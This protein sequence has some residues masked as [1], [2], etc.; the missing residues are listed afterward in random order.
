MPTPVINQQLDNMKNSIDSIVN[1]IN[2]LPF[3]GVPEAVSDWLDAHPEA[4]TT[5]QDGAITE[6]K[7]ATALYDAIFKPKKYGSVT[8]TEDK[9]SVT[10]QVGAKLNV[11]DELIIAIYQSNSELA[12]RWSTNDNYNYITI[13]DSSQ[14][15]ATGYV[16]PNSIIQN[17]KGT[18]PVIIH[19]RRFP[20]ALICYRKQGS[21]TE[22]LSILKRDTTY[23]DTITWIALNSNNS[24]LKAGMVFEAIVKRM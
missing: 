19:I 13:R 18:S 10:V 15:A 17:I 22:I 5:V 2:G 3:E 9:S 8:L 11:Y 21:E 24:L 4:T 6:T 12:G 1:A 16:T 23:T 20:E 14:T 7:L